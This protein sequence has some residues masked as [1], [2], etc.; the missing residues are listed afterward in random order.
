MIE[1]KKSFKFVSSYLQNNNYEFLYIK[2]RTNMK[3]KKFRLFEDQWSDKHMEINKI[4][5]KRIH[6]IDERLEEVLRHYEVFNPLEFVNYLKENGY[7]IKNDPYWEN[8]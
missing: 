1:I 4:N 7:V 8:E 2:K 5:Y 3:I 6:D